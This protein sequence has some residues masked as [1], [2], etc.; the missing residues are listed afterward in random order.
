MGN[1]GSLTLI[2]MHAST[3]GVVSDDGICQRVGGESSNQKENE[4]NNKNEKN[5]LGLA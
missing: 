5:E 1:Y 3:I 2:K 4:N